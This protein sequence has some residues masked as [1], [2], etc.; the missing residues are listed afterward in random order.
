MIIDKLKNIEGLKIEEGSPIYVTG[1][2]KSLKET[3]S[4]LND[5]GFVCDNNTFGLPALPEIYGLIMIVEDLENNESGYFV[6]DK[7]LEC[8]SEDE[9]NSSYNTVMRG[10]MNCV[11]SIFS[12]SAS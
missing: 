1:N 9:L 6:L 5:N 3:V 4:I 10:V 8:M 2:D 12:A 11:A 7:P